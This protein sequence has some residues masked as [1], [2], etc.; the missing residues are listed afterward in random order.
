MWL[1]PEVMKNEKYTE[2]ADVYSFG[3]ILWEMV[4]QQ[5]F[6]EGEKFMAQLEKK[7]LAGIRPEIPSSCL[8]EVAELIKDCWQGNYENRPAFKTVARRVHAI[9]TEHYPEEADYDV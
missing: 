7:V 1:A 5:Q 4:A 8:P 3:V 9:M 2:K 6:F